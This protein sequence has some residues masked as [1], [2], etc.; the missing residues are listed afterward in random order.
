MQT[1]SNNTFGG[2][3]I[4]DNA[5]TQPVSRRA[6]ARIPSQLWGEKSLCLQCDT[7][8]SQPSSLRAESK[9]NAGFQSDSRRL[10][11]RAQTGKYSPEYWVCWYFH[12]LAF[13]NINTKQINSG[14]LQWQGNGTL[15]TEEDQKDVILFLA[16]I[17][18]TGQM[19][20]AWSHD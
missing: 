2:K 18:K 10:W 3:K 19:F 16:Q 5:D 15:S 20:W 4:I 9:G 14:V 11:H 17:L 12:D 8:D 13:V 1:N 6:L 7:G